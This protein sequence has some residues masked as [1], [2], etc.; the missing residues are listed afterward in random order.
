VAVDK[1][2]AECMYVGISTDSG[3]FVHAPTNYKTLAKGARLAEIS[4]KAI[5]GARRILT[6]IPKKDFLATNIAM[7][8][9]SFVMGEK[10]AISCITAQLLKENG[11]FALDWG[12]Q[13]VASVLAKVE[14]VEAGICLYEDDGVTRISFR[15]K[16]TQNF[17]VRLLAERFS[18]GGGHDAASGA[19][20]NGKIEEA[21]EFLLEKIKEVFGN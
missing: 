14:G 8:R 20:Y 17:N 6:N 19:T 7:Q 1:E 11:C 2:M 3:N 4:P 10:V 5:D 16:N 12:P 15:S 21:R 18:I 9:L 13:S